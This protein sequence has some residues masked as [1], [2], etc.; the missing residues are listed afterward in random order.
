VTVPVVVVLAVAIAT[1]TGTS[2]PNTGAATGG[3]AAVLPAIT[4]SV[5]PPDPDTAAPCTE[6]LQ[7]LP[8]QLAGLAPRAVHP[9]PDTPFV[10]AWGDPPILLQ[11]GVPRPKAL[12]PGSADQLILVDG[13]S[14]LP[15][16]Q[17]DAT[18]WTAIDRAVYI[19]VTVPNSYRQPPLAGLA[20][21]IAAALPAVCLPQSGPGQT[22]PPT[23]QLCTR[24]K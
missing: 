10:V 2:K 5:Q 23:D 14:F 17:G 1:L 11:C 9:R 22:P 13:V 3:P 12:A 19:E 21:A 7:R 18:I 16:K 15:V 20:D 24:R 4:V 8:T 6:L